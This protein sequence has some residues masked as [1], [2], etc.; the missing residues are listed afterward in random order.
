[1]KEC[2]RKFKPD[3]VVLQETM[4]ERVSPMLTRSTVGWDLSS[5][6]EIPSC[7][8]A[9]GVLLAWDPSMVNK[10]DELVC[11]FSISI[12]FSELA[13]RFEWMFTG[14]YAPSSPYN[15]HLF[16]EELFDV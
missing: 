13:S 7:G 16:W 9:G 8:A 11:S 2:I 10:V 6:I 4:K 1:M 14:V 12:R 15:R 5:W 3:L